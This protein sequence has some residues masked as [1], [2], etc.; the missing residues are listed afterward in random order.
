MMP[1]PPTRRHVLAAAG[2]AFTA[3]AVP[4][5]EPSVTPA[6]HPA[7]PFGYCLNTSTIR[8]QNLPLAEEIDIAAKIG[9]GAIEPWINEIEK[10]VQGGGTT[11]D[12]RKRLADRG[13]KVPSAIGFA[14]WIIDDDARRA[15]GLEHMKRDM[16][17]VAQVGGAR[18]AAPAAGLGDG[19]GGLPTLAK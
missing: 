17:L 11:A 19:K 7:E 3:A 14:E 13:L 5:Q 6:Q 8:G 18:I 16:D 4:A 12:L 15:K 1:S 10:H 9:F 2:A